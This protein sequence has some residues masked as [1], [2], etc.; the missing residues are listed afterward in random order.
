[1]SRSRIPDETDGQSFRYLYGGAASEEQAGVYTAVNGDAQS[2]VYNNIPGGTQDGVPVPDMSAVQ[3][4]VYGAGTVPAGD[5]SPEAG[6]IGY[7]WKDRDE[8]SRESRK[9]KANDIIVGA[10]AVCAALMLLLFTGIIKLPDRSPDTENAG[11]AIIVSGS[12]TGLESQPGEYPAQAA[13]DILGVGTVIGEGVILASPREDGEA[14]YKAAPDQKLYITGIE[15][16]YYHVCLAGNVIQGYIDIADVDAGGLG[17]A[18][19]GAGDAE[20]EQ[21][22]VIEN[23]ASEPT[24][25]KPFTTAEN[26]QTSATQTAAPSSARQTAA[27][28]AATVSTAA[29]APAARYGEMRAVWIAF[30]S[31]T[32]ITPEKIDTMVKT[33]RDAGFNAIMFH[34]RPFGDAMYPSALFP[35][36]HIACG[37]QGQ[38]PANGF[39][40]LAYIVAKAHENGMELHAW[41]NPL[42]IQREG[43]TTPAYLSPDN[44]YTVW[45]GDG[46]SVTDGY[47]IDY[48]GGKYYNPAEQ[49]VCD[50]IAAGVAEIVK[51]YDV[52]G[53]HWDDYFYPA[54]DDSFDDGA[55]YR[56]YLSEGGYKSLLEW[57]ID[58]INRLVKQCRSAVKE[59]DPDCV[60]GISPAGNI[61]NCINAGADIYEWCSKEGYVDYIC[62]QIYWPFDS[63]SAPFD[64]LCRKWRSLVTAPGVKF[65]VGLALYKGGSQ[66][67]DGG[68]WKNS[69]DIIARQIQYCRSDPIGA[70]GY[71]VFSYDDLFSSAAAAERE[72]MI[73]ENRH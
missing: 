62:P 18:A 57:R 71:M 38:A 20:G 61:K 22:A 5:P 31:E 8:K 55:Y 72:N 10:A 48:K 6:N 36:S 16:G 46:D 19:D 65:Y 45:R 1:M 27:E 59:N 70:D 49:K 53:I 37:T 23:G 52:D 17:T 13:G 32:D 12:E 9:K 30:F 7:K 3:D 24:A 69:S 4:A 39:D 28:T 21:A 11:A 73:W 42:R 47:V 29:A 50:L 68:R 58:N 15:E 63:P 25:E 26:T 56:R 54:S 51:N 14:V 2:G 34:V 44:P 43:G 41:I 67:A 66:T 64:T 60:F 35:W 33:S 40:P